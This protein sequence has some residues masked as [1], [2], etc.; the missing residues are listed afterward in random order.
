MKEIGILFI[1]CLLMFFMGNQLLDITDPVESNYVITAKEML[2]SGDYLSPRIYGNYWYDKPILFYWELLAAFRLMGIHEFAARFCPAV[3]ASIGVFL[4]YFFG[5]KLYDGRIGFFAAVILATSMEYWYLAHAVITDMTLFVAASLALAFFYFGY[6][7]QNPQ[8]YYGAYIAAAI[9]VLTK[10]PV[11]LCLPGLIIFLFLL[12]QRDLRHFLRL[13]LFSGMAVFLAVVSLWYY[14]MYQKH[15]WDFIDTFFGVH[16]ALRVSVSEHPEVNVWYYYLA[17]FAVGFFPWGWMA[18]PAALRKYWRERRI[19]AL[20]MRERFLLVWAVTVPVV[21]QCFATK[22]I[23]YTLP[24]MMPVALLFALYFRDHERAFRRLAAGAAIV[25]TVCL[26]LV[27]APLCGKNSEKDVAPVLQSM[28]GEDTFVV[29]FGGRYPASLVFYSGYTI[30]RTGTAK[31]IAVMSPK[32]MAWSSTNVMPL[33]SLDK[34]PRDKEILAVVYKKKQEEFLEMAG[35]GW[36]LVEETSNQ[37][38]YR[39]KA[40]EVAS[41]PE[42][43]AAGDAASGQR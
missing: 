7:R 14:P 37:C 33:I 3:M 29:S 10:G 32:D 43:V 17:V 2:E 12:W 11:G 40:L 9:A 16:N 36:D 21:F 19:P 6:S 8:Y 28:V 26:F 20:G 13:R 27:A 38:I 30:H 15:G 4:T 31:E 24:Y 34:L 39:R 42:H 35:E 22:Y 5:K 25:W 23:T 1:F 18:V 41:L